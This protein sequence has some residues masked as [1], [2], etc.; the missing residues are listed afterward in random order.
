MDPI[1]DTLGLAY[2]AKMAETKWKLDL[3]W[4]PSVY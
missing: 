2:I 4:N 1:L 3:D